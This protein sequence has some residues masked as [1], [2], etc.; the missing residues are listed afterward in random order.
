MAIADYCRAHRD[1]IN[2]RIPVNKV[3]GVFEG[4]CLCD[5]A[6]CPYGATYENPHDNWG[7]RTMCRI[8]AMYCAAI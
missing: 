4:D 5:H 1:G 7:V 8:N 3:T 2:V 6:S